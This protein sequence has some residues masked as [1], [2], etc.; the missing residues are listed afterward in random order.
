MHE[1]TSDPS[2]L[3]TPEEDRGHEDDFAQS[4]TVLHDP[5]AECAEK[6]DA[7]QVCLEADEDKTANFIVDEL[8]R[9]DLP[10]DWR[11]ALVLF[12]E[13]A[14]YREDSQRDRLWRRLLDIALTLREEPDKGQRPVVSSAIRTLASMIPEE[15]VNGLLPLLE[16]PNPI[17]TRLVTLQGV[18]HIFEVR[19]P[20]DADAV[21]PLANRVYEL[22]TKFLDRDWLIAGKNAAIGLNTVYALAAMGDPRLPTSVSAVLD[23]NEDWFTYQ[24]ILDSESLIKAWCTDNEAK[25]HSAFDLVRTQLTVLKKQHCRD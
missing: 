15:D 22:A 14:Q 16:P 24:A 21:A 18:A 8:C 9:D 10:Q 6:I 7:I 3:S 1:V 17:E 25:A 2:P 13:T 5:E 23:L 19:P 20:A 11:D 4:W 12:A